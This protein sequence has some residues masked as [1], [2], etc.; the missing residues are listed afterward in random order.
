MIAAIVFISTFVPKGALTLNPKM[1]NND[2]LTGDVDPEHHGQDPERADDS[3][4]EKTEKPT[5]STD[6]GAMIG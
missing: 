3:S 4:D 1:I 6:I 5:M 2:T